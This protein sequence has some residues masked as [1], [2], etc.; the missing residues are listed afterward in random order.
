MIDRY[1][2]KYI[3]YL[4]VEKDYSRQTILNY[5]KDL[6]EFKAFLGERALETVDYLALRKFL[7]V[8]RE[9]NL[10]SRSVSRKLSCLRSFFR[11]LNR[12]G[13]LKNDPTS[14]ISS[15]KLEKHLP[16]FMTEDEV[17]KLVEAPDTKELS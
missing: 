6:S 1:I 7:S 3:R 12:E 16:V 11:F 8:L 13:L 15:P 4:E 2:E 5:S 14:A 17:T 10:K 9:R